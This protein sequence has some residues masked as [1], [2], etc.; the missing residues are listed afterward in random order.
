MSQ[1][2]PTHAKLKYVE[3]YA[4]FMVRAGLAWMPGRVMAWLLVCDPPHQTAAQIA[5][6]LGASRGAISGAVN[7]LAT[8]RLIERVRFRGDRKDYFHIPTDAWTV[9]IK[10]GVELQ[11]EL[12][13]LALRGMDALPDRSEES[14]YRLNELAEFTKFAEQETADMLDKWKRRQQERKW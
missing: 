9:R 14:A 11:R 8:S 2:Q 10:H 7:L 5:D 1:T 3:E 13:Q 4:A 6:A 12:G